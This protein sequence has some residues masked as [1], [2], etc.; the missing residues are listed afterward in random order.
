MNIKLFHDRIRLLF[1]IKNL[2][3]NFGRVPKWFT[4]AAWKAAPLTGLVGSNPTPT[5]ANVVSED[6]GERQLLAFRWDEKATA[7]CEFSPKAKGEHREA[8]PEGN[9]RQGIDRRGIPSLPPI[10]TA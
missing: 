6:R 7:M 8:R 1:K 3:F 5:A 4:G 10:G 2:K 9:S